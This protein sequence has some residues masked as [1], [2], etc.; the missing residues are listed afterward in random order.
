MFSG[1]A[2]IILIALVTLPV[3]GTGIALLLWLDYRRQCRAENEARKL[4]AAHHL[5]LVS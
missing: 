3:A 2:N 1:A 4:Y 5:R